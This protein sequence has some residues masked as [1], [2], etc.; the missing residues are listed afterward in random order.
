MPHGT[1]REYMTGFVLAVVLTAIPF[2]LVMTRLIPSPGY[3]AAIV[4]FCAVAQIL[5]HMIYFLHMTPKAEDGWLLLSTIFTI[6]LVVI[7]LAGSLWVVFHLNRN[8]MPGMDGAHA[9]VA[10]PVAE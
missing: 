2:I 6:V 9:E 10:A 5:V 8:M 1:Y 7:T 3:T 4:L